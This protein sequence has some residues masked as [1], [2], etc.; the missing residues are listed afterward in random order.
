M[1]TIFK[2][3]GMSAADYDY[4]VNA[5]QELLYTA[6]QQYVGMANEAMTKALS[7]FV[8]P[9]PTINIQEQ[10]QLPGG[11]QM[12]KTS[13]DNTGAPVSPNGGWTVGYPLENFNDPLAI[14]DV[15]RAYMTPDEWQRHMDTVITRARNTKRNAILYRIFNNTTDTFTD[16]RFGAITVQPLALSSQTTVLYPPVEGSDTEAVDQHYLASGYV[17]GS[18]SDT[19]NPYATIVNELVEHGVDMTEDIPIV[20]FIHPDEQTVTEALTNFVPYIPPSRITA[21]SNTDQVLM[22]S[23]PIPGKVI[24]YIR[25]L[26]WVSVWRWQPT[27][28]ITGV[29]LAAPAPLKMRADL[30]G[31][32]LGD[33]MLQLLPEERRGVITWNHWRLRF[34]MGTANRIGAVVMKLTAGSYDIPTGYS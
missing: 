28:Y 1:S 30:P 22:P 3:A 34:G 32:N 21:G 5:N 24:G 20:A 25:G 29:N 15:D 7:A 11:G 26:C 33:G 2:L 18:I 9:T 17:T 13:E 23:K 16:K 19:N 31:T 10:F 14:N 6:A 4:V 8:D 12:Q 27:G